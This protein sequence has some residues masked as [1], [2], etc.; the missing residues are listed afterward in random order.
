MQKNHSSDTFRSLPIL[1]TI[2]VHTHPSLRNNIFAPNQ[3]LISDLVFNHNVTLYL[4]QVSLFRS[5]H[6]FESGLH[7]YIFG[8]SCFNSLSKEK[9]DIAW[10]NLTLT[11]PLR[12]KLRINADSSLIRKTL[13]PFYIK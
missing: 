3:I 12:R 8:Q 13:V 9:F 2:L 1:M 5:L 10:F 7:L 4:V 11:R 6:V